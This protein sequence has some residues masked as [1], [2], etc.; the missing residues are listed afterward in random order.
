MGVRPRLQWGASER[1]LDLT[2]RQ[3]AVPR[4]EVTVQGRGIVVPVEGSL[5][6]GFFRLIQVTARDPVEAQ[7]RAIECARSDWHSGAHASSN[8]SGMLYLTIET[9]GLLSWWHRFL[10][11]PKGYIFFSE[12]GVQMPS[13]STWSGHDA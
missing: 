6:V 9:I 13:N 2:V 11:A 7:E 4:Y 3:P 10:G 8:R 1:P 12:D 5:A